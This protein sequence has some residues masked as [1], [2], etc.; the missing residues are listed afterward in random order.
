MAALDGA[1]SQRA[2]RP[3]QQVEDP[4]HHLR[5]STGGN[6][7]GDDRLRI[8]RIRVRRV[9]D[10]DPRQSR[11]RQCRRQIQRSRHARRITPDGGLETKLG[12]P[13]RQAAEVEHGDVLI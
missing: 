5:V 3:S 8:E 2:H 11:H 9:E 1:G 7:E 4:H 10:R 6:E 13:R 12:G